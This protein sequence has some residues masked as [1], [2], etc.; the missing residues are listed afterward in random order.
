[1]SKHLRSGCAN[2]GLQAWGRFSMTS[3]DDGPWPDRL[4]AGEVIFE[5]GGE[6][7]G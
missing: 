3:A 6:A 4:E 2:E 1:M 5:I 7:V